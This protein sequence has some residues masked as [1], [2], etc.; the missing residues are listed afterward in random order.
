LLHHP[1]LSVFHFALD[2][3]ELR[4]DPALELRN[5]RVPRLQRRA[6]AS[7]SIA[8]SIEGALSWAGPSAGGPYEHELGRALLD[9]IMEQL[10]LTR[11]S[12]RA[13]V[14]CH[15]D[16]RYGPRARQMRRQSSILPEWRG[17]GDWTSAKASSR[18]N[19]LLRLA[20]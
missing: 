10:C 19:G 14:V 16:F 2:G 7:Y 3:G 13:L 17:C 9:A 6:C 20:L 18:N 12:D 5:E 11:R 15:R 1:A 4:R 8:Q